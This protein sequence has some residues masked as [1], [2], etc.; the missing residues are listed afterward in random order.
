MSALAKVARVLRLPEAFLQNARTMPGRPMDAGPP[1][2]EGACGAA[3][4]KTLCYFKNIG[5]DELI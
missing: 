2:Y 5:T 4:T 1:T 3:R